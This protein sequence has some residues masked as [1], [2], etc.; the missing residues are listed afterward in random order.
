MLFR[1]ATARH[2]PAN[3]RSHSYVDFCYK[4]HPHIVLLHLLV[5]NHPSSNQVKAPKYHR[6]SSN[7]LPGVEGYKG[8]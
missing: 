3:C 1:V 5:Q 8:H 7:R 6:R 4:F 2:H